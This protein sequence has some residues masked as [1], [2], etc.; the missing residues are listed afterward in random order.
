MFNSMVG[1]AMLTFP[2]LYRSAGV[3]TSSIMLLLSGLI[4]FVTCRIYVLHMSDSDRDVEWT[5]RRIL[6][7]KW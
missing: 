7:R 5:I 1:G 4:S 2:I 6:G 3:V